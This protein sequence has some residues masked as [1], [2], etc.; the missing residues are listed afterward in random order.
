[1]KFD[2]LNDWLS[3]QENLHAQSIDMGLERIRP[4][5]Q[6]LITQPLAANI[7]V[8]AGTNGKGST[9]AFLESIY[10]AAGYRVGAYSSPHLFAYNERIRLD[11]EMVSDPQICAAFER[12]NNSR[13]DISLTYFE[14]GTL[15][16]FDIFQQAQLDIVILEVGLGGRLD[17]V[18][19]V[20]ADVA[21]VTN[22]D[23]DHTQWLGE[24]REA[25]AFEK[26]AV[27]RPNTP[28]IFADDNPPA[29]V[30]AIVDEQGFL[31]NQ[32]G[33]DFG[34]VAS[35]ESW[36]WWSRDKK[37][38]GLQFPAL[39]GF[40][41][42]KNASCALLAVSY[43]SQQLPISMAHI[44]VGISKASLPGRFQVIPQGQNLLI[45]DVAHNT[46]GIAAFLQQ[47]QQIPRIGDHHLVLG[48]L[49]DK[50]IEAISAQLKDNI[51]VWH[52]GALTES[53]GL[54]AEA[55]YRRIEPALQD[56]QHVHCYQDI[57]GAFTAAFSQ[58]KNNDK[59]IVL[60]SFYTVGQ[61][62]QQFTT[63]RQTN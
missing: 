6:Q 32:I 47:L 40:H 5:Y 46:H 59:L 30:A 56:S 45:F 29:N 20:D 22:I 51:D 55:L 4:V 41:Q 23:L 49:A 33:T 15:A 61:A 16:A 50:N 25:I 35:K 52:L 43:L 44:R 38:Y 14:F 3:W 31:F 2:K 24:T 1:M 21:I 17:A 11:G 39:H 54:S 28:L 27:G 13:N 10:V 7:I 36:Q 26:L 19:L 12:V 8:V 58:L 63:I 60:G 9:V 53:R 42:L 48:M 18:N 57:A 37:Y 62:L 34:F